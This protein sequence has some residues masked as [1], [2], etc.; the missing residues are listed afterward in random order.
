[1]SIIPYSDIQLPSII[2]TELCHKVLHTSGNICK[3]CNH[4]VH[5][6]DWLQL[7]NLGR[8]YSSGQSD[9]KMSRRMVQLGR[10]VSP[11]Q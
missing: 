2:E 4:V 6:P 5:V 10:L 11:C 8:A 3:G 9:Q 7:P 1:M